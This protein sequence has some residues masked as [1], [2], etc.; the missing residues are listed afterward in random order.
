MTPRVRF[1]THRDPA[2]VPVDLTLREAMLAAGVPVDAPCGG[3]GTCGRCRVHAVG[4]LSV[5]DVDERAMLGDAALGQGIRLACRAR[6]EGDVEARVPE[7]GTMRALG[8]DPGRTVPDGGLPVVSGAAEVVALGAV[9]DVGTTTLAT[10]LV[11]LDSGAILGSATGLNPQ[12]ADGHDVL[13]RVS[14]ALEGRADWLQKVVVEAVEHMILRL[15]DDS[16]HEPDRLASVVIVGNTAMTNLFLGIDVSPLAASPYEGAAI[17]T[18][19]LSAGIVGFTHI[20][21]AC[22]IWSMPGVSAFVG[23]DAVAGLFASGLADQAETSVLMDLGTNGEVVLVSDGRMVATSAA[24][25]PA[26]EGATISCGMRAESGAI[27][28]VILGEDG[29]EVVTVDG[30]LPRGICGSGLLD[31]V[32]LLLDTGMLAPS[33]RLGSTVVLAEG[34]EVTQKD[35]RELQLAKGAIRAALDLLLE[36]AD[37][38]VEDVAAVVIAGGFGYHIRPEAL[39]GLGLIPAAWAERITFRGNMALEGGY[40]ALLHESAR[41]KAQEIASRMSSVDLVGMQDFQERFIRRMAL[42]PD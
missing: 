15:L 31:V 1:D 39:V 25:G 27:E 5:P 2:D 24:A 20:P 6:V 28:R 12:A 3:A 18:Q 8:L 42:Q 9:V 16:G 23:G 41:A 22:R 10:V 34:V 32:A 14:A 4:G 26:L 21:A 40:L 30:A 37:V 36:S 35:L 7:G 33:G 17:Q 11:G 19:E 38:A 29:F 13:S